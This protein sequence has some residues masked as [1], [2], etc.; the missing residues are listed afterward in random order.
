MGLASSDQR[1]V[2]PIPVV[3]L[4]TS[5][6]HLGSGSRPNPRP[7]P[8]R[9]LLL[10]GPLAGSSR[11]ASACRSRGRRTGRAV[12]AAH[13]GA[14]TPSATPAPGSPI[15]IGSSVRSRSG[16]N[17]G[18]SLPA[19]ANSGGSVLIGRRRRR[20]AFCVSGAGAR[21]PG[22]VP[23]TPATSAWPAWRCHQRAV[24]LPPP[25]PRES[26]YVIRRA[27]KGV[28]DL[29]HCK[30]ASS[31]PRYRSRCPQRSPVTAPAP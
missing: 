3:L 4:G 12:G 21:H 29:S 25:S 24:P 19:V 18:T 9:R 10:L 30:A 13:A 5:A 20:A 16:W 8:P 23:D 1:Q 2:E 7:L 26:F 22:P 27:I 31:M 17:T 14:A 28:G 6:W 15:V 11:S